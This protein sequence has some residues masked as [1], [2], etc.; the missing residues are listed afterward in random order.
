MTGD[1][2]IINVRAE[3]EPIQI[4]YPASFITLRRKKTAVF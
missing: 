1:Y 3:H 2:S 4:I